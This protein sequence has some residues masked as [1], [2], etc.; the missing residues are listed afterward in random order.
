MAEVL[1]RRHLER[2][3]AEV[4]VSSAGL[5]AGGS[6]ATD[7]AVAAMADRGLDLQGHVSRHVDADMLARADLVIAMAREHVCEA[8]AID[9]SALA[10]TFTLK[11]LVRGADIAG[12]RA[13]GEE[14]GAWLDR[15]A[16]TRRRADLLGVGHRDELDVEDPAGRQRADYEVTAEL[17]DGLLAA[18]VRMAFPSVTEA[19]TA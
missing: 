9:P 7:H 6:R 19:Q 15:L 11:E 4:A 10:K 8:T 12:P 2:S 13:P 18:V 3:G 14:I 16:V 1:L 5:L 17:L